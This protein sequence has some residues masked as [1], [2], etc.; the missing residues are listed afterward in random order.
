MISCSKNSIRERNFDPKST[1]PSRNPLCKEA[2]PKYNTKLGIVGM[3]FKKVALA[4][5]LIIAMDP[6]P[7]QST[8]PYGYYNSLTSEKLIDPIYINPSGRQGALDPGALIAVLAVV[9][10]TIAKKV[11]NVTKQVN[12]CLQRPA[13]M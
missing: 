13:A 7:S 2:Y 1:D 5:C 9:S 4:I 8:D 3:A 11:R 12:L 6:I 10:S